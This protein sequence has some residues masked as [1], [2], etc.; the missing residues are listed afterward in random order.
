[1]TLDNGGSHAETVPFSLAFACHRGQDVV[2]HRTAWNRLDV[3][4]PATGRLLTA[5]GPTGCG[6]GEAT[7]E[8]GKCAGNH[9]ACGAI[10]T[11]RSASSAAARGF[12]RFWADRQGQPRLLDT[13]GSCAAP[14]Y[15]P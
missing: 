3:S 13:L 6:W 7:P 1:M 5:R 12:G 4:D 10:S 8:H 11:M 9:A 2:I 15:K 14:P